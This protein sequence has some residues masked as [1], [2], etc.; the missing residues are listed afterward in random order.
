[1]A[2]LAVQFKLSK[3]VDD[4]LRQVA[5][6]RVGVRRRLTGASTADVTRLQTVLAALDA[7]ASTLTSS[8]ETLQQADVRPTMATE[9]LVNIALA[10]AAAALAQSR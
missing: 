1:M 4:A 3:A 6:A 10:R 2:D 8:L 9:A 5:T 7:A